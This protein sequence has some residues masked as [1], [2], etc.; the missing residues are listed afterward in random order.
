MAGGSVV[1]D[2]VDA[3][4]Q[5]REV[6]RR[7]ICQGDRAAIVKSV[8]MYAQIAQLRE[9][10]RSGQQSHPFLPEIVVRDIQRFQRLKNASLPPISPSRPR[11]NPQRHKRITRQFATARLCFDQ[12]FHRALAEQIL[13]QI[14]LSDPAVCKL[15]HDLGDR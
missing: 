6:Q 4:G 5:L 15:A 3:D 1:G 11:T 2:R 7:G 9:M 14:Q 13:T 10:H 8:A 12:V